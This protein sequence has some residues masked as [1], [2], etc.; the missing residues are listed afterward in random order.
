MNNNEELNTERVDDIP[1]LL[2]MLE[3]MGIQKLLDKHFITHGNWQGISLGWVAVVWLSYILSQGDHRLSHVQ[4]WVE[5]RVETLSISTGTA[6][7]ALDFSDDRLQAELRYLSDTSRWE[8][9]EQEL[10]GNLLQVYDLKADRVRLD[11]TSAS[12]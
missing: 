6:I 2:A 10:G 12:T 11:T 3:R 9:F 7:R 5:N 1:V 8:K 4:S